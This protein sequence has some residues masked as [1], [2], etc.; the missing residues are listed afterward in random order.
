MDSII[1]KDLTKCYVCGCSGNLHKHHIIYGTANRK[2]SEEYGLTVMLCPAHHNMSNNGVH[3]NKKLDLKLKQLAEKTWIER[4]A[5][6]DIS[7][8]DKIEEFIDVFG[9]N[10]LD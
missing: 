2:N 4:F 5:S 9:R 6:K 7:Y 10:Y 3:F 8:E 1:Q